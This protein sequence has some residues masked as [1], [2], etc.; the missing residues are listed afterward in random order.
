MLN[1]FTL[2]FNIF[3]GSG[4]KY[5]QFN[6]MMLLVKN[7]IFIQ[8]ETQVEIY[9]TASGFV[10]ERFNQRIKNIVENDEINSIVHHDHPNGLFDFNYDLAK[11]VGDLPDKSKQHIWNHSVKRTVDRTRVV[12]EI[13]D[14]ENDVTKLLIDLAIVY[15]KVKHVMFI[16]LI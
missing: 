12:S 5:K 6:D 8:N 11:F 10:D 3:Y 7:D 14:T 1:I 9:V 16:Y 4:E 13:A 15:T 2:S